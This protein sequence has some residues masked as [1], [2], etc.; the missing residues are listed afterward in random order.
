MSARCVFP[1]ALER[2]FAQ[3]RFIIM[4]VLASALTLS[5]WL[6]SAQTAPDTALW[7]SDLA[8]EVIKQA[9]TCED[10]SKLDGCDC[11]K[12]CKHDDCAHAPAPRG[13]E[14]DKLGY[15]H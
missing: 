1:A 9:S 13:D 10:T 14:P 6:A 3:M 12:P 2:G 11:R 15:T 4:A 7:V 5:P 8:A